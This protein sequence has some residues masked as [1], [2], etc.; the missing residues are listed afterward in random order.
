MQSSADRDAFIRFPYALYADDPNWVPPLEMERKDF[1]NPKKN[2]WFEFGTVELFLARRNGLVVG[3]IA[4]VDDPRY[5]E[6]HGSRSWASSGC[7]SAIDDAGGGPRP[8]RRGRGVAARR[9]A[10]PEMMGPVNFSTNYECAVLV[11]GFDA[12]PAVMMAYNPRYY[13]GA[14]RGVRASPRPRTSGPASCPLGRRRRRR[15]CASR[16]RSAQREGIVVRPVD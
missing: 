8:L 3:R 1:L 16:R 2:P 5:N 15:W 11:E 6:F 12:P 4:A 10:S 13:A 7:S 14:L 9:R